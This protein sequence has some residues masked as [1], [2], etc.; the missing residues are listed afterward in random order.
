MARLFGADCRIID[1]D[2]QP[3]RLRAP[4]SRA[5]SSIALTAWGIGPPDEG[6]SSSA[7]LILTTRIRFFAMES[8]TT[9][10]TAV[11]LVS[12]CTSEVWPTGPFPASCEPR[13]V[14]ATLSPQCLV[15]K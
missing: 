5:R 12:T 6:D 11:A 8:A 2:F 1:I 15:E 14:A 4:A 13:N 7:R 3:M 9:W 10:L